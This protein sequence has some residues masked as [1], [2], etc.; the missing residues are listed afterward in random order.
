[1]FGKTALYLKDFDW[2]ILLLAL[3]IAV[4]GV[5]E[6]HSATQYDRSET[7]YVKQ[8]YRILIGLF[9]MTLVMSVDYHSLAENVPYLY[10]ASVLALAAVLLFGK[11]VSGSKSWISL[12]GFF[13]L[14]PSE[15]VKVVVV[16]ALARFLCE[17]RTEYLTTTDILK[18]S[19]IVGLPV[20]LVMLQPDLG[21][22][23]TFMPA[24]LIGLFLGGLR[25]KWIVVAAI[26]SV[27]VVGAGWY[28]LKGYQR[29]RIYT[30]LEPERDPLGHGYHSIQS[31]IAVGSGGFWG[32]G[33]GKGSQTRLG[34]LP[35]RHTDFIFS[36]V[37]E[38]LGFVGAVTILV[39]YFLI[40]GRAIHIA[41]TARDKLGIYITLGASSILMFHILENIG[42]V[43][44]LMPI[45]GIPLPL[46]SYGGSSVM[47]TFML[48]GLII[49][50]RMLR[51]VN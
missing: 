18:A 29:E 32:K 46:L 33:I 20:L 25:R 36:V 27:L 6:I 14:Q 11:T 34:F 28:N 10:A 24:L 22:A 38:E 13:E 50:V 5:I 4:V 37:G 48:L 45:T 7:F 31:K 15:L 21:S 8:I 39:I 1:M 2:W 43:V 19:G 40:I 26:L 41:Q 47:A 9:L 51:Y 3:A 30:F 17:I 12:G 49:N 16:V 35:E 23:M 42:M 44:G